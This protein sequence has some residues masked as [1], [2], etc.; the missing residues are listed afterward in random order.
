MSKMTKVTAKK[1]T[2]LLEKCHLGKQLKK[3]PKKT[4][5]GKICKKNLL[6]ENFQFFDELLSTVYT[7]VN[8]YE[9]EIHPKNIILNYARELFLP[10][11]IIYILSIMSNYM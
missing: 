4:I 10:I 2:F 6:F 8:L 3:L 5:S 9:I 7:L 11:N 1:L